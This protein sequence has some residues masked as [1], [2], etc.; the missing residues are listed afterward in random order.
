MMRS[1]LVQA[2]QEAKNTDLSTLGKSIAFSVLVAF[3][4]GVVALI[5]LYGSIAD[6]SDVALLLQQ[7]AQVLPG[8]MQPLVSDQVNELTNASSATLG[9]GAAFGLATAFWA[10]SGGLHSIVLA[11]DTAYEVTQERGLVRGRLVALAMGAVTV[12]GAVLVTLLLT[13]LPAVRGLR[14]IV[15]GVSIFVWLVVLYRYAPNRERPAWRHVMPGA[16]LVFGV[17]LVATSL[18]SWYVANFTDYNETYGVLG[19]AIVALFWLYANAVILVV[20]AELNAVVE[21]RHGRVEAH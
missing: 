10:V 15:G 14:P 3:F 19:G 18:M 9:L 17:G 11:I 13:G 8:P 2:L 4:P 7:S 5:S 6:Q 12:L 1:S 20:G 21:H 16:S